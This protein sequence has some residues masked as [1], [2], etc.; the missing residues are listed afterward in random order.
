ME[1]RPIACSGAA[2]GARPVVGP[3]KARRFSAAALAASRH[4]GRKE[5]WR[6]SRLHPDPACRDASRRARLLPLGPL[7]A[8]ALPCTAHAQE[9]VFQS[10]GLYSLPRSQDDVHEWRMA[11]SAIENGDVGGAVEML[12]RLLQRNRHGVAQTIDGVDRFIGMRAAVVQTLRD[13]PPAGRQAYDHLVAR[14]AGSLLHRAFAGGAREELEKLARDFPASDAGIRASVRLGDID[15]EAGRPLSAVACYRAA[16]DATPA[17]DGARASTARRLLVALH[18]AEDRFGPTL[19]PEALRD[20]GE[21]LR[22]ALPRPAAARGSTSYGGGGDN[23]G[24]AAAPCGRPVRQRSETVVPY[25]FDGNDLAMHAVGD[26]SGI[27]VTDGLRVYAIDPFSQQLAWEGE[28]PLLEDQQ[29]DPASYADALNMSTALAPA[30]TDDTVVVALQVP[31]EGQNTR[32]QTIDVIRKLPSRRLVAFDR[33][34]GKRKWTHFDHRGGPLAQRFA[35][36]EAAAPPVILGD[37]VYACCHDQTGSIAFYL[38]AYD[39]QT[40]EPRWRRLVCSSQQE[41]NMFGNARFEFAGSVLA[42]SAGVVYGTTN[43]GVCFAAD[44][45]DGELR[46]VTGYEV[47]KLPP[48]RLTHQQDRAVHF[49]NNPIVLAEGIMACTPLDSAYA[50]G[51]DAATGRLVWRL[52]H[53]ANDHWVRWLLGAIGD[54]FIFSGRGVLAVKARSG[55]TSIVP[56]VRSVRTA[57]NLG[58]DEYAPLTDQMPRGAIAED[59]VYFPS[60]AGLAVFDAQ[61]NTD[62]STIDLRVQ[63]PGNLLLVDGLL[64]SARSRAVEVFY[65]LDHMEQAAEQRVREANDDPSALLE[66]ALLLRAKAGLSAQGALADRAA[67]ILRQG[68]RA[69]AARGLG[70]STA[71]HLRLSSLLFELAIERARSVASLD[72]ERAVALLRAARDDATDDHRWLSAQEL[73]LAQLGSGEDYVTELDAMADRFGPRLHRFADAKGMLPIEAYALWK[74]AL[75]GVTPAAAAQ[76]WQRLMETWGAVD[77]NGTPARAV[78]ERQLDVLLAAHGPEPYAAIE[79]RAQQARAEAGDDMILLAAVVERFPHSAAAASATT[80]ILDLAAA[81]GDLG[82]AAHCFERAA[83]RGQV[84]GGF[85]RRLAAT[86]DGA[87]NRALGR[88]AKDALVARFPDE[89]SDFAADAGKTYAEAIPSDQLAMPPRLLPALP[90]HE[91]GRIEPSS[92]GAQVRI[93]DATTPAGFEAVNVPLFVHEGSEVL[94]AHD[95]S[96]ARPIAEQLYSVECARLWPSTPVVVCGPSTAVVE[97]NRARGFDT[98]TGEVRW[99]YPAE[100]GRLLVSL[101]VQGGVLVLFAE[102]EDRPDADAGLLVGIEPLSGARL[103]RRELGT[104]E[105]I[106]PVASGG[107]LWSVRSGREDSSVVL[108]KSAPL[109]GEVVSSF[110]LSAEAKKRLALDDTF[111]AGRVQRVQDHVVADSERVFLVGHGVP[112]QNGVPAAVVAF[113]HHG[114]EHW[115]W[116]GQAGRS[117]AEVAQSEEVL[118]VVESGTRAGGRLSL[119][120]KATGAPRSELTDLRS[121]LLVLTPLRHRFEDRA[122][123]RAIVLAEAVGNSP[124]LFCR[125][126]EPGGPAF[127]YRLGNNQILQ[128]QPVLGADFL[129]VLVNNQSGSGQLHLIDLAT[130]QN[131]LPDR[132]HIR[133]GEHTHGLRCSSG[134]IALETRKGIMILSNQGSPLR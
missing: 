4:P 82:A 52:D 98:L 48:T 11:K 67:D 102:A 99:E 41:V 128:P 65:D 108:R 79:R 24:G 129:C 12:H 66:L 130:G 43:L 101:G 122:L 30:V 37:T 29:D 134:K 27:F 55:T 95:L 85:L 45:E 46:W 133:I 44:V 114:R 68:L 51:F 91:V 18:L 40:G 104:G 5:S 17:S 16:L 10:S 20:M 100:P 28:G 42:I 23:A 36:H 127:K 120:D 39:L 96:G 59:K 113:S 73:I 21:E 38:C 118:C 15:L 13:L 19:L 80:A 88:A 14:E 25:G 92:P 1:K 110:A 54:E 87:G 132:P 53:R 77:L 94:R 84:T 57:E 2:A 58:L 117:L 103:Y 121:P 78:A 93:L 31:N 63:N 109:S 107:A 22:A 81:R 86:A 33:A 124:T 62:R 35:G 8:L 112:D 72:P 75:A 89:R 125:G 50:L 126:F 3:A 70:P 116:T 71:V 74:G 64:V 9:D 115:S 119:L 49:A 56:A 61:G 111:L 76:R 47:T 69:A 97:M 90:T 60:A 6:S 7:L 26:L 83:A 131:A 34:T 123:D 105:S 32:F 106:A